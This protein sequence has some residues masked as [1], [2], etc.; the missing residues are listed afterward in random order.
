TPP[1]RPRPSSLFP[2]TTL[3]RSLPVGCLHDPC[4][5]VHCWSQGGLGPGP[6]GRNC[7]RPAA[8]RTHVP[9]HGRQLGAERHVTDEAPRQRQVRS[10]EHTSELQSLRHLVCRLL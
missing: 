7:A 2:Y 4:H 8:R 10:E 6:E 3:F 5:A 9:S 1:T